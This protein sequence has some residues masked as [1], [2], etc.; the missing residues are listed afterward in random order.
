MV[1]S[2]FCHDRK[3]AL[4]IDQRPC[5]FLRY[6]IVFALNLNVSGFDSLSFSYTELIFFR[7]LDSSLYFHEKLLFTH[8]YRQLIK[9]TF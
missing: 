5:R 4:I 7:C 1:A 9:V 6:E 2:S 3:S 8:A